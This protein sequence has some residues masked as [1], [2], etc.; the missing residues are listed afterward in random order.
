PFMLYHHMIFA[1]GPGF[2]FHKII[3]RPED[4]LAKTDAPD[5][6]RYGPTIIIMEIK[7][8]IKIVLFCICFGIM[9][10]IR[11]ETDMIAAVYFIL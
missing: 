4:T 11:I 9:L 6:T 3:L 10:I 2:L 7:L 5:T 1:S 8:F